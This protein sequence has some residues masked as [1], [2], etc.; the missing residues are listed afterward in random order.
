VS[1]AIF[2]P[3]ESGVIVKNAAQMIH[4]E[5]KEKFGFEALVSDWPY[6]EVD[7]SMLAVGEQ[8][9][10]QDSDI[11]AR[12]HCLKPEGSQG[13]HIATTNKGVYLLGANTDVGV[14]YAAA[15]FLDNITCDET[16]KLVLP[17][18]EIVD[19][20][21]CEIRGA[22]FA[23]Y[24]FRKFSEDA[25]H[26]EGMKSLVRYY[27]RNRVN[28]I[29]VEATGNC[30]PGDLTPV[31]TFKYFPPLY[32]PSR[33]DTVERRRRMIN[34]LISY[35]H[36]WG[37][38]VVLYTSEFN[39]EPDI[40]QRCP[41]LHGILPETWSEGRHSYIRGCM[42]LSKDIVWQYLR[43]KVKETLESLPEL[44]GIELWM[45]EVPSEFGICACPKCRSKA[46][47]EWI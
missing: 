35:A 36:S 38:K 16:G 1:I 23:G 37:V 28:M 2:V 8:D 27:A 21:D 44:D 22:S 15:C 30:W 4:D 6:R 42:C 5:I 43:A 11:A 34:E 41:E 3:K 9:D 10:L 12:L 18:T 17:T 32:D 14:L 7:L 39:H 31:V 13:Y 24:A 26:L 25:A 33:V 46:R 47:H 19:S 20:P 45:V 29:T 40:Y